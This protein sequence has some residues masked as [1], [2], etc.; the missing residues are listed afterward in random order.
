MYDDKGLGR[1]MAR[2]IDRLIDFVPFVGEAA[3]VSDA[4]G[5][6]SQGDYTGAAIDGGLLAVGA[7]PV[8]GDE[9]ARRARQ[10]VAKVRSR[11]ASGQYTGGPRGID[12]PEKLQ[13]MQ[14]EY[15]AQAVDGSAGRSWYSDSSEWIDQVAPRGMEQPVA[16]ALGVTSQGTGVDSN[17]GFTVK[18]YNQRAS[19]NPIETGRFPKNQ[20][21]LIEQTAAG[22]RSHLGPKRQ[23]FADNL[24]VSFNPEISNTAVHDIWQGRAFGYTHPNGKPWDAGFSPQQHAFMDEQTEVIQERMNEGA[25]GGFDDWDARNIQA[26]AWTGAKIRAGDVSPEDAAKHYG[27]FSGKYQAMA[28]HEQI[29]GAGTGYMDGIVDAPLAQ[30]EAYSQ[31]ASWLNDKGQDDLYSSAGMLV[32][33]STQMVGAYT[34]QSTGV[35]EIN[36]GEVARPLVTTSEG[37]IRA[38]ER[39]LLDIGESSRAFVDV[40]N[41]GAW[42]KVIP[43]SQSKASEK[44][45]IAL[46][47]DA[48]PSPEVMSEL[49]RL[50]TENGFF[51]VDTGRGVNFINDPYSD[52][53]ANRVG[54]DTKK[55]LSGGFGDDVAR[56]TG[57]KPELVK[58]ETGYE[59]YEA[60]WQ[61]GTG[62]GKA[63]EQFLARL[64]ENEVFAK[65]IEPA[66]RRKAA[67]NLQ[68]DASQEG[69]EP[70]EDVTNA[71][72]ILAQKGLKGLR[73]AVKSGAILPATVAT[74]LAPDVI[75][76]LSSESE[77]TGI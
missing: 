22:D 34:P 13:A 74:I 68:R 46:E 48:S 33:P 15:I 5:K 60:A 39:Q 16:D 63:T 55:L 14:D 54:R 51:A 11:E 20:S 70:R 25:L 27:D 38:N 65:G 30:R 12:T 18:G 75:S 23:P 21:P 4:R 36:P 71:L 58:I 32:E 19:G 2:G 42:H 45:S 7:V 40:Q 52:L 47:M 62:S 59:D 37:A 6:V 72:T 44:T 50:A 67:Q 43:A 8:V 24:S 31:E 9:V 66:L 61:A 26:A 49:N 57:S 41:A 53:G 10:G 69:L 56:L 64:A 35:L 3:A 77:Q 1:S 28:T 73:A 17:L 29:P 76:E